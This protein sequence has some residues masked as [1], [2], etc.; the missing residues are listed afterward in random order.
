MF[1]AVSWTLID[2]TWLRVFRSL[3]GN[4][5]Q[6]VFHTV[7]ALL[8]RSSIV[9]VMSSLM[10]YVLIFKLRQVFRDNSL[11]I[12]IFMKTCILL[13]AS[14]F[15]NFLLHFTYSAFSL[16]YSFLHSIEN[17][18]GMANSFLWLIHHSIGWVILF[19]FTQLA[20]DFYEKYSPGV[21]WDIMIGRYIRPKSQKRIVMFLDLKDSTPIAEKLDS[22]KYFSFIRDFIYYVSISL[23]EYH[24]RIYQYVG[25]EIVVSWKYSQENRTN[26]IN[27]LML[28]AH[29]IKRNNRYF[30]KKYG[31]VPAFKAG[32]HTG[33][34]TVGE[35]GIIKK[36]VAMGGDI[37]NTAARIRTA[38]TELN[39]DYLASKDFIDGMESNLVHE[40]IGAVDLKGKSERIE[41]YALNI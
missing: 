13:V 36:D 32:I 6:L 7:R 39:H 37:M 33:E 29:L 21:F 24:G 17:F 31:I 35:I 20:I 23:L 5:E 41:L 19:L 30:L 8:L 15:L 9:F 3:G 38:C 4:D 16:H 40:S 14:L 2:Y 26:C 22:Q 18:F 12:S 27:A 25:D 28:A 11:L 10:G 1:I 34:I